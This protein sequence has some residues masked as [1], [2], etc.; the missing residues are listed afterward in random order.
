[1]IPKVYRYPD[2]KEAG[3]ANSWAQLR[4][5]IDRH[6]FPPGRMLSSNVRAW[7][8]AEID[9][10]MASRPVDGPAPRGVAARKRGRPSKAATQP[11]I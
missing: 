11:T 1:M 6:G 7:T 5:M 4:R 8:A 9:A 3:I 2:L 10:W